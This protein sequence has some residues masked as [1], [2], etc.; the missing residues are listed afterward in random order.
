MHEDEP[1]I[2]S[3]NKNN[4][5]I[6]PGIRKGVNSILQQFIYK[7]LRFGINTHRQLKEGFSLHPYLRSVIV[8]ST[9]VL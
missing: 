2:L 5:G 8:I 9:L 6:I 4:Q 7:P 1:L 3:F